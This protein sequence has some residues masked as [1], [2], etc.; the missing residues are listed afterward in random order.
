MNSNYTTNIFLLVIAICLLT[1]NTGT[2][3][4]MFSA[5]AEANE[6]KKWKCNFV[7][8]YGQ[9]EEAINHENFN[10]FVVY[11]ITLKQDQST[12]LGYCGK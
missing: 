5:E 6:N 9:L 2:F 7:L 1:N 10:D 4:N 12:A 8:T 3:Y 11:P